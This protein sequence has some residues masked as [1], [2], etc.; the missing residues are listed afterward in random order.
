MQ[1]LVDLAAQFDRHVA[2]V[3]RGVVDNSETAQRLGYCC[4]FRTG[5]Q[6]R[7]SDVRNFPAGDVVCI[8]TGSQGEP[9]AA[10]SRIAIDDHRFV[11]VDDDDVVVFSARAIPGNERAIG[12]VM[13]HLALRGAD[14]IY[15]GQKHVHVSGHGHVEELKLMHSLVRP[16]YFVPIHGEYRQLARHA[17]VAQAVS[18]SHR[19]HGRS[20]TATC[21]ASTARARRSPGEAEVGRRLIDGTRTG[22]VADEVLRDRRHLAG[23]GLVVPMLA[24]NMQTG[25]LAGTPEIIT[26]GFV[27]DEASEALLRDAT[28]HDPRRR[29][30]ARRSRNEPTWA[31]CA[32]ACA[33]ELQRVLRRKA[34]RRPLDRAR[35]DGDLMSASVMSRRASEALGVALFFGALLWFVALASYTPWRPGVVLLRRSARSRRPTSPGTFG[36]FVAESS[37]QLL[38]YASFLIPVV[39]LVAGWHYFWC[40]TPA[41]RLHEVDRRGRAAALRRGAARPHRSAPRRPTTRGAGGRPPRRRA[42]RPRGAVPQSHR[43]RDR[44]PV[45]RPARLHPDDAGVA[46]VRWPRPAPRGSAARVTTFTD[47]LKARREAKRRDE[48]RR[49]VVQKHL[50]RDATPED[51]KAAEDARATT[52]RMRDV[53]V[54]TARRPRRQPGTPPSRQ[55]RR[56]A[57]S[58]RAATAASAPGVGPS[59][60]ASS[61]TC[62][63]SRPK[64]RCARR[65]HPTPPLAGRTRVRVEARLPSA[66]PAS[67]TLP[68][69]ALL[70]PAQAERKVDERELMDSARQLEDKCREFSVEGNVV[71]ILPG[72][73]VTTYEF[74]PDAGVKYSKITGLS[75]DLSLAMRAESVLIDRIPGQEHGRHPDPEPGARVD[76]AARAARVGAVPQVE[77]EARHRARQDDPRRAVRQRP[78]DDAASAHRRI[79]GHGQVGR[80]ERDADQHPVPR[81]ARTRCASS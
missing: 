76:L 42:G 12:R 13:N 71:Q 23:D 61:A 78:G 65:Q 48:Q 68:P 74:K 64:P 7:D 25:E 52:R 45:A 37:F 30:R 79:H 75:E 39:L 69:L 63:R 1:I 40:R 24:V 18:R 27:V 44:H 11:K 53:A 73:V 54:D 14:V 50:G 66:S 59:P 38:G 33:S 77:L 80:P 21:S 56:R 67:Y 51:V 55:R 70:D 58:R 4:A 9:A 20:T 3:G 22:E 60:R 36:A 10:L 34:G 31:C 28:A 2:F 19:G 57:C 35:G 47:E 41:G 32:S 49:E 29:A 17:R 62:R 81:H 26:R 6:I 15:E 8:T 72:P 5:V 46:R 43:R 16:K